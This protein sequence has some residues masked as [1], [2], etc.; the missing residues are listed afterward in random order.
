[1]TLQQPHTPLREALDRVE[2]RCYAKPQLARPAGLELE[3]TD[4][5]AELEPEAAGTAWTGSPPG[6]FMAGVA[7][8]GYMRRMCGDERGPGQDCPAGTSQPLPAP[9]CA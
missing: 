1:M 5:A 6:N 8:S 9:A 4:L 7:C 2:L 3:G